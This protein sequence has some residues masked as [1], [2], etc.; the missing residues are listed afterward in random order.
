M[1]LITL[2]FIPKNPPKL[3]TDY[4]SDS[5]NTSSYRG[6]DLRGEYKASY[7]AKRKN[8]NLD[9]FE[10]HQKYTLMMRTFY[11]ELLVSPYAP[12]LR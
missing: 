8:S 6:D 11:K 4:N 5:P 1:A 9:S 2:E 3:H 12:R 10:I 7:N